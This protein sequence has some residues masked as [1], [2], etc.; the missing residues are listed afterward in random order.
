MYCIY[1]YISYYF[2]II[3]KKNPHMKN[4]KQNSK[5]ITIFFSI[6][7]TVLWQVNFLHFLHL[8]LDDGANS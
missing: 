6:K 1:F 7:N 4:Y 3:E 2:L 5:V 8:A